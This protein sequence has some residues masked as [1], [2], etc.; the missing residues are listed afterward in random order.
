MIHLK[1][2]SLPAVLKDNLSFKL[3]SCNPYFANT[4]TFSY[5]LELPMAAPQNRAIFGNLSRRDCPKPSTE[6]DAVLY[7]GTVKLME[8]KAKVV[9][10]TDQAVKVQLLGHASA[11]N[12]DADKDETY[13]D[14]LEMGDWYNLL[15][16]GAP[17]TKPQ[18]GSA[19]SIALA[20]RVYALDTLGMF[21]DNWI[22]GQYDGYACVFYPVVNS[23]NSVTCNEFVFRE[24]TSGSLEFRLEYPYS[25]P[26]GSQHTGLP[27]VKVAP[28]PKLWYICKLI[29][30]ATGYTLHDADNALLSDSFLRKIFIAN[31]NIHVRVDRCLP[32]WTVSEWWSNLEAAFGVVMVIDDT[33]RSL[34]LVKRADRYGLSSGNS[35][36]INDVV[37]EYSVDMDADNGKEVSS[38]N[39]GFADFDTSPWTRIPD[40]LRSAVQLEHVEY[41]TL[42][43]LA[44]A[45]SDGSLDWDKSKI[46]VA[47]DGR[48]YVWD[49]NIP[50]IREVDQFGPRIVKENNSSIDVELK[51]I[52]CDIVESTAKLC[53]K[54]LDTDDKLYDDVLDTVPIRVLSRPDLDNFSWYESDS[55]LDPKP[56]DVG[57]QLHILDD[58]ESSDKDDGKEDKVYIAIAPGFSEETAEVVHKKFVGYHGFNNFYN[59]EADLKYPRGW[60]HPGQWWN[61]ATGVIDGNKETCGL[62]LR[63]I[64]GYPTL[65]WVV[66][67]GGVSVDGAAKYCINFIADSVPDPTSLFIIHNKP[68]ICEKLEL[69]VKQQGVSKQITGFFYAM[70]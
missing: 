18:Y 9:T 62:N 23:T 33:S 15:Y 66:Q 31:A 38:G 6:L 58:G 61:A 26:E 47:G 67:E 17:Y 24:K 1:I 44:A 34:K 59:F 37:D 30:A 10:V 52:P 65:G 60:L 46:Y 41:A 25:P 63:A 13:I 42:T 2:N 21:Y 14:E 69:T 16:G 22:A 39:T 43:D 49:A 19:W 28:Q 70:S 8:G 48:H 11:Y 29:A 45:V 40:E 4:S 56:L 53:L 68:Y 57:E 20:N 27:Q 54:T 35:V 50:G 12:Y 32:H 55:S 7:D 64:A 36:I 3:T 5:E 51:F